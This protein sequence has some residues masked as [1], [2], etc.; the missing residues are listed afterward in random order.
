MAE[1][2]WNN[3]KIYYEV[4]GNGFPL[5]ILNGIMMS[6]VSYYPFVGEFS[7][8][9]QVI[10]LDFVDQGKSDKMAAVYKHDVQVEVIEAVRKHLAIGKLNLFG[11]SYGGEIALQYALKYPEYLNR[12]MVF[13]AAS[14][15]SPWLHDIGRAWVAAAKTHDPEM[16]YYVSIPYVYSSRFYTQNS[17]W[18]TNR[19][20]LLKG[21]FTEDFLDAMIRLIESLEGYDIRHKLSEL[22]VPTLIVGA[23]NDY[24]T[25]LDETKYLHQ[26][27][28]HSQ[29]IV[30]KDCGHASMYEKPNEFVALINGFTSIEADIKIVQ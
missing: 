10:L 23:D 1:L 22:Q 13:N 20:V 18:M 12:L 6:H 27:I 17:Q 19:K 30:L 28:Q 16:F 4:H 7:K 5:F 26:H 21:I 15:T 25:P 3:H 9:Q 14:Y 29:Y 11:I 2:I 24:I 8:S